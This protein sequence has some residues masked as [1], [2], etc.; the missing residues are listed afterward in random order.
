MG[1]LSA[2]IVLE[3]S[4]IMSE[5][6][7]EYTSFSITSVAGAPFDGSY[8]LQSIYNIWEVLLVVCCARVRCLEVGFRQQ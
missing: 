4:L 3:P 2:F 1:F 8:V 7:S 5:F 6:L